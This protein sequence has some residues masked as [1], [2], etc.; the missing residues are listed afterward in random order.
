MTPL[1]VTPVELAQLLGLS[2]QTI[3]NR[4]HLRG[5]LPLV[6]Y[7]GRLPR[8]LMEDV[9]QWIA[10]KQRTY[11]PPPRRQR[12]GRPTK[13]EQIARRHHASAFAPAAAHE[14]PSR[15]VH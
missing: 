15:T 1:L 6:R 14:P 10:T 7:L 3:Y 12:R 8:F 2:T 4:I 13:A 9:H 5:D 11:E